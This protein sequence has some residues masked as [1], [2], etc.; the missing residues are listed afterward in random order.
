MNKFGTVTLGSRSA[1]GSAAR[2]GDG[3]IR[4]LARSCTDVREM[5]LLAVWSLHHFHRGAKRFWSI[6][7]PDAFGFSNGELN[8]QAWISFGCGKLA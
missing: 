2:I 7:E 8:D 5:I 1:T 3:K 4:D 6:E